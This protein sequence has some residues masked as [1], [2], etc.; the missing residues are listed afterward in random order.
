[1]MEPAT[2]EKKIILEC[3]Y[4]RGM[5]ILS[6]VAVVGVGM[7]GFLVY[8]ATSG[9]AR[10]IV[11]GI[12]LAF[13]ALLGY[14]A[15][16][17]Q[18]RRVVV[19][20]DGV[21]EIKVFSR[22][23]FAFDYFERIVYGAP[24][25]YVS[26]GSASTFVDNRGRTISL[27]S[28]ENSEKLFNTLAE[29]VIPRIAAR[30]LSQI[31]A[32]EPVRFG[33]LDVTKDG[34]SAKG[35]KAVWAELGELSVS[36]EGLKLFVENRPDMTLVEPLTTPNIPVILFISRHF[37]DKL[38]AEQTAA[39][40][41]QKAGLAEAP[42]VQGDE[43]FPSAHPELGRLLY[44]EKRTLAGAVIGVLI[45]AGALTGLGFCIAAQGEVNGGMVAFLSLV[46]IVAGLLSWV[47]IVQKGFAIY[48]NGAT[49]LKKTLKWEECETLTYSVVEQYTNGAFTG[50]NHNMSWSN[51][52][53]TIF[54]VAGTGAK[55]E[56][57]CK[58]VLD[59]A[60]P[61]LITKHIS[62]YEKEGRLQYGDLVVD[63]QGMTFKKV[64]VPWSNLHSVDVRQGTLH[65]WEQ[66]NENSVIKFG[67]DQKNARVLLGVLQ[68][69]LAQGAEGRGEGA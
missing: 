23:W 41:R 51:N 52:A 21:D 13:L 9:Q 45:T 67:L 27:S 29:N 69:L 2:E 30:I 61:M 44:Y 39:P 59:R 15:S 62:A 60:M 12:D 63:R 40:G 3:R 46:A 6:I 14:I 28:Y 31:Q 50:C 17:A 1:M 57:V 42:G 18:R 24:R 34:I 8:L 37:F 10:L 66:G 43:K 55:K 4:S 5:R 47:M 26:L 58:I 68:I 48:E 19:H 25:P 32:G 16:G 38:R 54:A 33:R 53:G 64:L 35:F 65:V 49:D 20:E 56:A 11:G 22:R 36:A 7:I